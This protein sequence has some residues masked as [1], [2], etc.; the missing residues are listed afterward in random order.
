MATQINDYGDDENYKN[1]K[2]IISALT[3]QGA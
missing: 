2:K 3:L 1:S